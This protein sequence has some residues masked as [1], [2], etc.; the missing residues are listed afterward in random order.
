MVE[1]ALTLHHA[2]ILLIVHS[3]LHLSEH[4]SA[5]PLPVDVR[6]RRLLHAYDP[7]GL[8]YSQLGSPVQPTSRPVLLLH[9]LLFF[10]LPRPL[11]PQRVSNAALN[12]LL[13]NYIS[14]VSQV[15]LI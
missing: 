2:S 14:L 10:D 3:A 6:T 8:W 15:P 9:S 4:A 7:W 12:L 13:G 5:G 1:R 11:E